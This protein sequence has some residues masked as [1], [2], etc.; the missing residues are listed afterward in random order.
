MTKVNFHILLITL[1]MANLVQG[2]TIKMKMYGME[3]GLS[4]KVIRNIVQDKYRHLWIGTEYGLNRYD[5]HQF[6]T[7]LH[8]PTDSSSISNNSIFGLAADQSN[9]IWIGTDHGLNRYTHLQTNLSTI[10][11]QRTAIL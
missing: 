7:F 6:Q 8:D 9:H 11:I 4:D 5:G 10:Y 1:L 3:D 2:Q